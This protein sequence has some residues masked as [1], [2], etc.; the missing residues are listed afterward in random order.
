MSYATRMDW[1]RDHWVV[2]LDRDGV[3]AARM[4]LDEWMELG[5]VRYAAEELMQTAG[6]NRSTA[7]TAD[8][9]ATRAAT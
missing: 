6:H 8:P 3:E 4:T 9:A 2:V 1:E 5:A 7:E